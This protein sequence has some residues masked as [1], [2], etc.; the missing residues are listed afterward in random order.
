MANESAL[1]P[2]LQA[3][4]RKPATTQGLCP[5]ELKNWRYTNYSKKRQDI[6]FILTYVK[7]DEHTA[8]TVTWAETLTVSHM[9]QAARQV[10]L[11]P[12]IM[13]DDTERGGGNAGTYLKYPAPH[14]PALAWCIELKVD[15]AK[16][17][18]S[19]HRAYQSGAYCTFCVTYVKRSHFQ[20][21]FLW[22]S[23]LS[24]IEQISIVGELTLYV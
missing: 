12:P 11:F 9:P 20:L 18:L 13:V 6:C 8:S 22:V 24:K 14:S 17:R 2:S 15:L 4:P 19:S 16:S 5:R 3:P 21:W 10:K 1:R 23:N 7:S